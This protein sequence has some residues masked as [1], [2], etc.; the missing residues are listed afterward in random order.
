MAFPNWHGGGG[1]TFP[2]IDGT[3][4]LSAVLYPW[5]D[6][7]K[8][9][10]VAINFDFSVDAKQNGSYYQFLI[11]FQK[12][13]GNRLRKAFKSLF[14]SLDLDPTLSGGP[15]LYSAMSISFS[16][17]G[18][19]IYAGVPSATATAPAHGAKVTLCAP[20]ILTTDA[21]MMLS[22]RVDNDI[23]PTVRGAGTIILT[24][25]ELQSLNLPVL[26]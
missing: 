10:I 17:T 16:D 8:E 4:N 18:Q 5:G 21:Q 25:F 3:Q 24:T 11:D 7:G 23:I 6:G 20:L 14:L 13:F 12:L 19:T 26:G 15:N 22:K 2:T 1:G 9:S